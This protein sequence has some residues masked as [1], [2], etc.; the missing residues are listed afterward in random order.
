MRW[1]FWDKSQEEP[2]EVP[3]DLKY[4]RKRVDT[5]NPSNVQSGHVP[6]SAGVNAVAIAA[7]LVV[8]FAFGVLVYLAW[9]LLF[10]T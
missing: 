1:K 9:E 4:W 6:D 10:N 7:A 2:E 3:E 5:Y 8:V